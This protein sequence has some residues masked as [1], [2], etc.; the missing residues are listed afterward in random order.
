MNNNY[1][2]L[3]K[4]LINTGLIFAGLTAVLA[5]SAHAE[6][7]IRGSAVETRP[8]GSSI[9]VSGELILPESLHFSGPLTVTPAYT[10]AGTD[11]ATI[12]TLTLDGTGVAAVSTTTTTDSVNPF[13]DAAATALGAAT[14]VEDQAALIRAGAGTEGLGALE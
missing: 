9:S 8:S 3:G 7:A 11:T 2:S 4:T 6:S 14:A 5:T 1:L 12:D 13:L 10:G